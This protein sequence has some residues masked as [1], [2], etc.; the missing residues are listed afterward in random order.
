MGGLASELEADHAVWGALAWPLTKIRDGVW[1][2][3][4]DHNRGV[5]WVHVSTPSTWISCPYRGTQDVGGIFMEQQGPTEPLL[6]VFLRKKHNL[7]FEELL[8]LVAAY[9]LIAEAVDPSRKDL[10]RWLALHLGDEAFAEEALRIDS[11][12]DK[13]PVTRLTENPL[14]NLAYNEMD[15]EDQQEYQEV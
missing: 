11:A 14:V 13:K 5:E 6:N 4:R 1:I 8:R 9:G 12:L 7:L 10:L 2:W 3:N 15:P